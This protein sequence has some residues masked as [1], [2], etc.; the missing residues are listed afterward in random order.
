MASQ[1]T[2]T[3]KASKKARFEQ[4]FTDRLVQELVEH[5]RVD[6]EM[7]E[8]ATKWYERSLLYNTVG[9]KANRGMSVVDT[10]EILKGEKL[11]EEEYFEASTLGWCVELLQADFL[12][13]DDMMD[14]SITRR[15]NPCWYRV[16]GVGNIAINDAFM[17]EAAIYFLLKK[18]F[19]SRAYYIDLVELF[20]ESASQTMSGQLLDLLTAPEDSVDLNR[21]SMQKYDRIVV[22]KTAYYSFY[23]PVALA[24]RMSGITN[25]QAYKV[26][27]DILIEMGHYFQIQDD[28]LD[29]FGTPEQIGKIGCD[30]VD[31]KCSW[32]VNTALLHATPDQRKILDENYGVKDSAKEKRVKELYVQEPISLPQRFEKFE[33]ESYQKL[34]SM[35][36]QVDEQGTGMKKEVFHA[37]LAKVYKRSK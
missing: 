15:D 12:V 25:E 5:V 30:I 2:A 20:L 16:E 36:D 14:Y 28:Y 34:S 10:V 24:M 22:Y 35:I 18:H 6:H 26:A 8:E 11:S 17:L 13:A 21:F 1:A 33:T 27:L 29:C 31:N 9:G 3:D 37:F 4:V 7:P 19:R 32:C 23:L